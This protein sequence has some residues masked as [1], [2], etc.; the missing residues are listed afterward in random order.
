MLTFGPRH[1]PG[2]DPD[3][4]DGAR[5]RAPE[6]HASRRLPA[7]RAGPLTRG[8][9]VAVLVVGLFAGLLR[10]RMLGAPALA[11]SGPLLFAADGLTIV[12]PS[13]VIT[14]AGGRQVIRAASTRSPPARVAR[15]FRRAAPRSLR[16]SPAIAAA[17]RVILVAAARLL[18]PV[19]RPGDRAG[20]AVRADGPRP[21]HH[22]GPGRPARPGLRGLLRGRRLHGRPADLD[23]RVRHRRIGRSGRRSR[24]RCCSRCLRRH[25][26]PADP[27][28]PRRLPGDRDAGLRRDHPHPGRLGPAQA[29]AGRPAR[30]PQHPQAD[31]GRRRPLP[32]RARTRSTTSPS[33]ARSSSR[34]WPGGCAARGS[35][36]PG[37]PSAR[38]RTW[39]RRWASTWSRR[40]CSRT[41]SAP[42]FAGLGGAHL[43]RAGGLDLP[44]SIK[45]FVSINVVAIVIVGGMGSIPGVVARRGLP[46]RPARA[47]PRVLRVPLPVLR[48][49]ADRR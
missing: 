18:G 37:S 17:R 6:P 23:G 33:S 8:L 29:V 40:S 7:S 41:C 12:G 16:T 34:S 21:E 1:R 24:S 44:S 32:R 31:R 46:H 49:R 5:P 27:G 22:P 15:C 4:L 47:V 45:L 42:A 35:G 14:V 19:L 30:H 38:T 36:A 2:L 3:R 11:E 25:P 20:R 43:R 9:C 26:G 48:R 28:H 13:V 10:T 39:R